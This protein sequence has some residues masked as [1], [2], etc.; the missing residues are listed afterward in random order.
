MKIK[1]QHV[2]DDARLI[3]TSGLCRRREHS[4]LVNKVLEDLP[5][6]RIEEGGFLF[7]TTIITG[8]SVHIMYAQTML[9]T[10]GYDVVEV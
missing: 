9:E 3:I 8:P 6:S 5:Q 10:A 7:R 4:T 1:V 2:N